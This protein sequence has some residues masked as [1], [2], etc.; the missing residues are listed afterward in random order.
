VQRARL[1]RRLLGG[2]QRFDAIFKDR[3]ER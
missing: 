3:V 2:A 1:L